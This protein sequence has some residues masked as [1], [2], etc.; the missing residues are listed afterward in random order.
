MKECTTHHYACDC[1][2]KA[3]AE[4][5]KETIRDMGTCPPAH[6]IDRIDNN[7]NYSPENCRWA[8]RKTQNNNTRSTH[9]IEVEGVRLSISGWAE[10]I[11]IKQ[12]AVHWRMN[13]GWSEVDAVTTPKGKLPIKATT[14]K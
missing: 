8:D 2:E 5:L 9:F 10:K 1:R 12:C 6:S 4:L 13:N 7:G 14:P 3:F 11:G